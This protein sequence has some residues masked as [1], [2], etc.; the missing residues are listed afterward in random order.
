DVSGHVRFFDDGPT[1][2][3][4]TVDI[5]A[6]STVDTNL[7]IVLDVS[8]SMGD[9]AAGLTLVSKLLAAKEAIYQLLDA[10]EN[11]GDV[12]VQLIT[13]STGAATQFSTWVD[14][15]DLKHLLFTLAAGGTTNYDAP[16]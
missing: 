5:S 10:Y 14:G 9:N 3:P 11:A 6:S 4:L 1:A 8:G 13:F 15:N 7:Q 16:L 12:K 2:N